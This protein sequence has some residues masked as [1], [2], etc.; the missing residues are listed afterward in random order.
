MNKIQ[1]SSTEI[2]S[3]PMNEPIVLKDESSKDGMI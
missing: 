3:D 2:E 1:S